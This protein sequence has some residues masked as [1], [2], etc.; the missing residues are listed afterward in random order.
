MTR[1]RDY[2]GS[3]LWEGSEVRVREIKEGLAIFTD[4]RG[5][6]HK[7]DPDTL[8]WISKN[9]NEE[10]GRYP[11]GKKDVPRNPGHLTGFLKCLKRCTPDDRSSMVGYVRGDGPAYTEHS[12]R[13]SD[14]SGRK[15]YDE[16]NIP[17]LLWEETPLGDLL[18]KWVAWQVCH[19]H[20]FRRGD[21]AWMAELTGRSEKSCQKFLN[22][23]RRKCGNPIA[24][25]LDV[26]YKWLRDKDPE[27][28]RLRKWLADEAV[29]NEG[30]PH[31]DWELEA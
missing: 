12:L 23:I 6:T 13:H 26:V 16:P 5:N 7:K 29:R 25:F 9:F 20:C 22:K 3:I 11:N 24:D 19:P 1:S 14:R 30:K 4:P 8:N 18:D 21:L 2:V 28:T 15:N 31:R 17:P 10:E 27:L